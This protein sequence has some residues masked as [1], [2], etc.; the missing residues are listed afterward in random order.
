[1]GVRK[2]E[3]NVG[4]ICRKL[5]FKGKKTTVDKNKVLEILGPVRDKKLWGGVGVVKGLAWT[6]YGGKV[7]MVEAVKSTGKGKI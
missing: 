5:A 7:L 1:M 2:L 6:A 4:K 3:R